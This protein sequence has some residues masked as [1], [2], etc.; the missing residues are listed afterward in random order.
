MT[1]AVPVRC[2][3]RILQGMK[4]DAVPYSHALAFAGMME[5]SDVE[6]ALSKSGDHRLSTPADLARLTDV[7]DSL[8][9]AVLDNS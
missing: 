8:Q 4:D 2:P 7:L 5:S 1:G 6:I 9:R 3:V